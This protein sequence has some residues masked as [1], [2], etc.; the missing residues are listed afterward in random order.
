MIQVPFYATNWH[1]DGKR[2]DL[3]GESNAFHDE[4]KSGGME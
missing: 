2:E 1:N 4:K 3:L